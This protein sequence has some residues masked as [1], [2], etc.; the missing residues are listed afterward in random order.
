MRNDRES[1][2]SQLEELWLRQVVGADPRYRVLRGSAG[3]EQSAVIRK[4]ENESGV[5]AGEGDSGFEHRLVL[6]DTDA[7]Q[8]AGRPIDCTSI[9]RAST[10]VSH[11]KRMSRNQGPAPFHRN[12]TC[13]PPEPSSLS[14]MG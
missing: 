10:W 3:R 12:Q 11:S 5:I 4:Q 2:I 6:S 8:H 1:L 9:A 14:T 13:T 7:E